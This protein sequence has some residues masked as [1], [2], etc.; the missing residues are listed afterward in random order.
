MRSSTAAGYGSEQWTSAPKLESMR[1][2]VSAFRRASVLALAT[3]IVLLAGCAPEST[4]ALSSPSPSS[5]PTVSA[6]GEPE[7]ATP[8]DAKTG[9]IV[10]EATAKAING[11]YIDPMRKDLV[12]K[13]TSG[14][15]IL[16]KAAEPLPQVVIDSFTADVVRAAPNYAT[17]TTDSSVKALFETKEELTRQTGRMVSSVV[18][19]NS[20]NDNGTWS[21]GWFVGEP[22]SNL[23]GE[24]PSKKAAMTALD[25][26]V[27][28]S[29]AMRTYFIIDTRN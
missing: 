15:H 1:L 26:W 9:D 12:V 5:T 24:Y 10:D 19:G 6:S 7:S 27:A 4:G 8:P 25:E 23:V 29:P 11:E 20:Y 2:D 28:V 18:F 13:L 14:E 17:D 3:G 16:V 22:A 21:Q